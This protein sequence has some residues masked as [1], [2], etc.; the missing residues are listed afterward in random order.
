[1]VNSPWGILTGDSGSSLPVLLTRRSYHAK[2]DRHPG[3]IC[4]GALGSG[5]NEGHMAEPATSVNNASGEQGTN[6]R[7]KAS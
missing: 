3:F 1:M 2:I 4:W 6:C 5:A 7:Q